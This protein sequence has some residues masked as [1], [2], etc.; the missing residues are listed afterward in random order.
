MTLLEMV[1]DVLDLLE[2]DQVNSIDDTD[3]ARQTVSLIRIAYEELLSNSD[4]PSQR[5]L[6]KMESL[7]DLSKPNYLKYPKVLDNLESF[8]YNITNSD[9]TTQLRDVPFIEPQEFLDRVLSRNKNDTNITLITDSSG[10]DL[11]IR[12]DRDPEYWTSFD[13]T[14]MVFDGYNSDVEDTLQESKTVAFGIQDLTFQAT[15]DFE[16]NNLSRQFLNHIRKEAAATLSVTHRQ[17]GNAKFEEDAREFR[18][19]GR[20]N[21]R[22]V[23]VDPM[24]SLPDYSKK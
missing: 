20:K 17:Q 18:A 2:V 1:Q 12:T 23:S 15:N 6:L 11:F 19:E 24:S 9:G 10:I 7:S 22:K 3:L 8:K 21:S 16:F 4:V 14:F 5:G 13:N